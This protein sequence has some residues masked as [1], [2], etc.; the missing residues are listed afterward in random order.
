VTSA[1]AAAIP[2]PEPRPEVT[3]KADRIVVL[4]RDRVLMLMRQDEVL[5]KFRVAL[6]RQP[7]G[8][9]VKQGDFRTPEGSYQVAGFNP[10][11]YFH[12]A[13]LISYPNPADVARARSLGVSPGGAIMIH[14]LDPAIAAK[15]R[16]DHWLFNWTRG[17]IAV[18]DREMDVIWQSVGLGTPV[19]I[20]P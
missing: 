16:D 10:D 19:E 3:G 4:K 12:R 11:S 18:T 2:P 7:E 1:A 13:I 20:R 17:C 6:G 9:K 15:W 14:G 5:R 8:T